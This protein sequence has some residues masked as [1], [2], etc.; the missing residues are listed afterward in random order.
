MGLDKRIGRTYLYAGVGYGGSC[1]PK[2]VLAFVAVAEKFGYDFGL[3]KEVDRINEDQ[4][5]N[6]VKRIREMLGGTVEGKKIAILG[7]SFKPNTD[8]IRNAPSLKI[9]ELLLDQGAEITAFDPVAMPNIK[10]VLHSRIDYTKDAYDVAKGADCLAVVT[11]WNEFRDLDL[12]RVKKLMRTSL[13]A[14]GRNIYDADKVKDLG[15][16]YF[17]IGR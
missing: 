13:I 15:F 1:L 17:G 5:E 10:K 12:A 4:I 2:D 16:N 3:L 11:D 8:D 6:F 7:L 14:D 9:I